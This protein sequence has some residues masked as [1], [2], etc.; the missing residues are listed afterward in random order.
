[1]R[2]LVVVALTGILT[3]AVTAVAIAATANSGSTVQ[4]Y[5]QTYSQKKVGKSTGTNFTTTSAA[6]AFA[7][8][9]LRDPALRACALAYV[10]RVERDL[11]VLQLAT[12]GTKVRTM[13]MNRAITSV[14]P[15][16]FA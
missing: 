15:P 4:T 16:C 5:D 7:Y 3:L 12:T 2:K 14:L 11:R 8:C 6:V 1:M 9:C 10:E 13:G